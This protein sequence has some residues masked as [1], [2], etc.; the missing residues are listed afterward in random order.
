MNDSVNKD[1]RVLIT[2]NFNYPLT[3][4]LSKKFNFTGYIDTKNSIAELEGK[5]DLIEKLVEKHN[6]KILSKKNIEKKII[7]YR[8]DFKNLY[9]VKDRSEIKLKVYI[10]IFGFIENKSFE[11]IIKRYADGLSIYGWIKRTEIGYIDTKMEG[12]YDNIYTMIN[13]IK[14][15]IPKTNID[16]LQIE[17]LKYMNEFKKFEVIS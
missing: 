8:G 15:D 16:E 5:E 7:Q 11:R 10:K 2:G 6:K 3:V 1:L 14:G 9:V 13:F 17:F 12:S 4:K